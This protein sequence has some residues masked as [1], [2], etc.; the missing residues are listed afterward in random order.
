MTSHIIFAS[1]GNDSVALVQWARDKGLK[2]VVVA[3]SNTGWA[4]DFWAERI[5]LFRVYIRRC[6]FRFME[7]PSEGMI[8]LVDR[9]KG[10]PGN[11]QKFCTYELKIK[12]ACI[13]MDSIDPDKEAI[14]MVGVRREE[15]AARA[16]WPEHV[17]DSE[18]H[19][20]RDLWSPL[21]RHLEADRNA[22][23]EKTIMPL[24]PY[25]SK[26]CFPCVNANRADFRLLLQHP[27]R[28]QFIANKERA[29]GAKR[30]MFRPERFAGAT[31]IE[32]V[33]R[34]AAY[35]PGQYIAGQNDLFDDCG[36]GMCGT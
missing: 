11:G 14:C 30:N 19:G 36:S 34:W 3:Y 8:P 5:N 29:M 2:D 27:Q 32:Q 21:V 23:I 4:A 12:P 35:S 20:G 25:R 6:G 10:W 15:S 26:E 13:W 33:A 31:G 1:G 24:L 18:N 9:K 22:L 7:I 16:N 17:A 28:I